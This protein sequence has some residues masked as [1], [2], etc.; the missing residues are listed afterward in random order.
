MKFC[1]MKYSCLK[2]HT[3]LKGRRYLTSLAM[4]LLGLSLSIFQPEAFAA[5]V[6]L[7]AQLPHLLHVRKRYT[8]QRVTICCKFVCCLKMDARSHPWVRDF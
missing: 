1:R 4:T 3:Y 8:Q 7:Q 5:E 2:S 6:A